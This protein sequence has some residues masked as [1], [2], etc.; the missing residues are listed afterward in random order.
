MNIHRKLWLDFCSKH[1]VEA[2]SVA[3]FETTTNLQVATKLIGKTKQRPVL[4]RSQEMEST[5]RLEC[6]K[7]VSDYDVG[8]FNYDGI[9]YMMGT[10]ENGNFTPPLHWKG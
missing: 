3:L 4:K 8:S 10:V 2:N 9:I 6:S 1:R 7:L 5:M